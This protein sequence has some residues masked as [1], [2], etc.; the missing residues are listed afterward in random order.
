MQ[1]SAAILLYYFTSARTGEV[2]ELTARRARA[3][4]GPGSKSD[5]EL[6]ARVI[7]ACY[8]VSMKIS[9]YRVKN[10]LKLN[11][12]FYSDHRTCGRVT[13]A[14]TKLPE[15]VHKG[16]LEKK[17]IGTSNPCDDSHVVMLDAWC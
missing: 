4:E 7:A 6:Q 5:E 8:K 12:T 1:I 13:Y 17:G 2:H 11:L 10:V 14:Y 9:I 15:G 16:L 3:R